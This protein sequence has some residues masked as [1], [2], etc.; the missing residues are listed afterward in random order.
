M[1]TI[2]VVG[3]GI[4]GVCTGLELQRRGFEV[5]LYDAEPPGST[6]RASFGNAGAF[7]YS[8]FLPLATPGIMRKVPRWLIDPLGPL[9]I[10]PRYAAQITPWLVRF[11]LAS[12]PGRFAKGVETQSHLM[13][14]SRAALE[15]QLQHFGGEEL[16][17]TDGQLQVY[18]SAAEFES[19]RFEWGL[20]ERYGIPFRLLRSPAEIAEVQPGLHPRFTHGG[21]TPTWTNVSDPQAWLQHRLDAFQR[22][23]GR[24]QALRV[25]GLRED[26]Q[27]AVLLSD[28]DGTHRADLIVVAAG[29]HSH[30]L[31][32]TV[33]ENFPLETERGYNTTLP[34]GAFDL[35]LH[36][37]FSGHG[38]VISRIKG[39]IRVGGAVEL[40]G[41]RAAPNFKRSEALLQRAKRFMPDLDIRG[42][43]PWMG[44]RPSL[45]DTAPVIDRSAKMKRLIYAFGH[46]HSG[47]T[48]AA[49]TGELVAD[50]VEN[51]T[52]AIP[53]D[54][55]SATRF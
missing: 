54:A 10:P 9:S 32:R 55:F 19:T 13:N 4:V 3:A 37:T 48:Q 36:V 42:G 50:L 8:D 11:G 6:A 35:R 30:L 45:P 34:A 28:Q 47:L 31:S 22:L 18:E 24:T 49:A 27:G 43:E 12:R 33:G 26:A 39:G 1:K 40:G 51:K 23:G 5:C 38:F 46:G 53:M 14:L 16:L 44:L 52:P 2:A 25:T 29:A 7:A 17:Q 41:I 21:F 15:R 20:R